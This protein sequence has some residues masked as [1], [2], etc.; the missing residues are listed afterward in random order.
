MSLR[1]VYAVLVWVVFSIQP[2]PHVGIVG[3]VGSAARFVPT[4]KRYEV[5]P[6]TAAQ[7]KVGVVEMPRA[8]LPGESKFGAAKFASVVNACT[9][10]RTV[11]VPLLAA[12][13]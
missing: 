13:R 3:S 5:A 4:I 8:A 12:M 7:V 11:V 10:P 6:G 9:D 1:G 2:V